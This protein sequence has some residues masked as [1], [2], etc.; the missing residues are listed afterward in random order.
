MADYGRASGGTNA[1]PETDYGHANDVTNQ[2][3]N[4]AAAQADRARQAALAAAAAP[5]YGDPSQLN[6]PIDMGIS[7][8]LSEQH[9]QTRAAY[10]TAIRDYGDVG[11][12]LGEDIGNAA[13]DWGAGIS[14]I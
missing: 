2:G 6:S 11:N 9:A 3:G 4:Y 13:L 7:A 10:G 12:T 1:G 14:E 8:P 5:T